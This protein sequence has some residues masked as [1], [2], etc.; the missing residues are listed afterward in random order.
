MLK[1]EWQT[2]FEDDCSWSALFVR[3][4][5]GRWMMAQEHFGTENEHII[6]A[7]FEV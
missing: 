6:R 1:F 5:G 2:F 4:N 3:I 7:C